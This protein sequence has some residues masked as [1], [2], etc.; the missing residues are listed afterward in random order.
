[1]RP[2]RTASAPIPARRRVG[3]KM[4]RAGCAE[5]AAVGSYIGDPCITS[6]SLGPPLALFGPPAEAAPRGKVGRTSLLVAVLG[7]LEL[8]LAHIGLEPDLAACAFTRPGLGGFPFAVG[9]ISVTDSALPVVKNRG[10]RGPKMQNTNSRPDSAFRRSS[11]VMRGR[12][13]CASLCSS[14]S[15]RVWRTPTPEQ[16]L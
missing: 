14:S 7:R 4:D 13:S 1:M 16:L 10:A 15:S 5:G 3:Q 9:A 2:P 8:I 6:V 12:S 11:F